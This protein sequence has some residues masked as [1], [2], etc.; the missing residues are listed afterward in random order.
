M[1]IE[2]IMN[3]LTIGIIA[4]W[5]GTLVSVGWSFMIEYFTISIQQQTTLEWLHV[6][7]IITF[8]IGFG[9][10]ITRIIQIRRQ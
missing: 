8:L 10:F 2:G 7:G 5:G 4:F 3:K 9:C 1:G 6:I